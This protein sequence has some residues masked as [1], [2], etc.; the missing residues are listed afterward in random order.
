MMRLRF[1]Y[2]EKEKEPTGLEVLN[3][4]SSFCYTVNVNTDSR[5][6]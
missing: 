3:I 5:S 1:G 6:N 4:L 2:M